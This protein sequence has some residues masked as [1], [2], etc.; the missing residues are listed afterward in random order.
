M[1]YINGVQNALTDAVTKSE[2]SCAIGMSERL[3]EIDGREVQEVIKEF[4][5]PQGTIMIEGGEFKT[6]TFQLLDTLT[7]VGRD[8]VTIPIRDFMSLRGL[9]ER[10][11]AV[12]SVRD[13]I[14]TL[15]SAKIDFKPNAGKSLNLNILKDGEVHYGTLKARFTEEFSELLKDGKYSRTFPLPSEIFRVNGNSNPNS[16]SMMRKIAE[17]KNI[18][19]RKS[20]ADILSVRALLEVSPRLNVNATNKCQRHRVRNSFERDLNIFSPVFSWNYKENP[21]T[22]DEFVN[23][24]IEIKWIAYPKRKR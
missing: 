2:R 7:A 14:S 8:E 4:K 11:S 20:N 22:F 18:N 21:R 1:N 17:H 6:R 16:Y 24:K 10:K 12:E 15:T 9:S 23:S 3:E 13:D 5:A 19:Y